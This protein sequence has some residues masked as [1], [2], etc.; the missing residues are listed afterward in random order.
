MTSTSKQVN[1]CQSSLVDNPLVSVIVPMYNAEKTIQKT[2]NSLQRQSVSN[3]EIIIVDDGSTDRGAE[4]VMAIAEGDNRIKL[5]SQNNSGVCVARN[6]GI[7]EPPVIGW[8]L[9]MLTICCL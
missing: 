2:L 8:H 9:L 5:I 1:C 3:I 6:R 4:L 7:D